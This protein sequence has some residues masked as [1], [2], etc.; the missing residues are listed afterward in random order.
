MLGYTSAMIQRLSVVQINMGPS[1]P[2]KI[3]CSWSP[4]LSI[5]WLCCQS[6]IIYKI[7]VGCNW[8]STLFLDITVHSDRLLYA[9]QLMLS[10]QMYCYRPLVCLPTDV[11]STLVFIRVL[12]LI[13]WPKC[14]TWI[15]YLVHWSKIKD[16]MILTWYYWSITFINQ[17]R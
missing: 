13:M 16:R 15:N 14:L 17:K 4:T 9:H 3:G 1:P 2:M 11:P 7:T 12:R 8:P 5:S 6:G 10:F